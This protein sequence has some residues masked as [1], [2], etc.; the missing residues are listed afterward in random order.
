MH[1]EAWTRSELTDYLERQVNPLFAA[2]NGVQRVGLEG[3]RSPAM[4]VWIDP[5]RLA[6]LNLGADDVMNAIR[7]NNVIATIGKTENA[8]QQFNLLS[9]ATLQTVSDFEQLI[10]SNVNNGVIRLGDIARVEKGE[11]RGT[12]KA[13][14]N[15]DTT[16]YISIWPL[17]GANEIAIDADIDAVEVAGHRIEGAN[18]ISAMR[19]E[20][21]ESTSGCYGTGKLG[22]TG[23]SPGDR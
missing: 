1:G 7:A 17:P 9:N 16:V 10:I 20:D 4:R 23:N 13:R 22:K 5:D 15:Q 19:C 3:G 21:D 8:A 12:I 6:A 2:I 18:A 14:Y 11:T